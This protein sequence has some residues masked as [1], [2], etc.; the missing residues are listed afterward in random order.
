MS[1]KSQPT[2][3]KLSDH[4]N[5]IQVAYTQLYGNNKKLAEVAGSILQPGQWT[6]LINRISQISEPIVPISPSKY[7]I[8]TGAQ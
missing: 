7:A 3:I 4:G 6:K 2:A 5:R 1:Y 8:K